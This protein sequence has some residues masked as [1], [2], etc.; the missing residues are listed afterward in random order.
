MCVLAHMVHCS[1]HNRT[2]LSL[3]DSTDFLRRAMENINGRGAK[4]VG[5]YLMLLE[6]GES[7]TSGGDRRLSM[8]GR[9]TGGKSP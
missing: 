8:A 1:Q 7:R 9:H 5:K 4:I 3:V 2:Q 6:V